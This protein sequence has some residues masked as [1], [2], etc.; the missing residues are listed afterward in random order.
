MVC[1]CCSLTLSAPLSPDASSK[2]A[3]LEQQVGY[4]VSRSRY[5]LMQP[6]LVSPNTLGVKTATSKGLLV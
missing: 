1:A 5:T 2:L 3:Q 6:R 4:L